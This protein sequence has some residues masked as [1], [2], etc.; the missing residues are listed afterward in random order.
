MWYELIV[1]PVSVSRRWRWRGGRGRWWRWR[2]GRW[3]GWRGWRGGGRWRGR[4]GGGR[5]QT[6]AL[7]LLLNDCLRVDCEGPEGRPRQVIA[8]HL[9]LRATHIILNKKNYSDLYYNFQIRHW[10]VTMAK[11]YLWARCRRIK[12]VVKGGCTSPSNKKD[13][14]TTHRHSKYDLLAL[15]P[16]ESYMSSRRLRVKSWRPPTPAAVNVCTRSNTLNSDCS[17][18]LPWWRYPECLNTL[19]QW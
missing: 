15:Y 10:V 7:N 12:G 5:F 14:I 17:T 2:R 11:Y 4:R 13:Q 18:H 6:H 3:I 8:H 9:C 19:F 16:W 1:T